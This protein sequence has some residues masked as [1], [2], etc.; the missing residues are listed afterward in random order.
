[1]MS[2]AAL[3]IS[4]NNTYALQRERNNEQLRLRMAVMRSKE[5]LDKE[6]EFRRHQMEEVDAIF[7]SIALQLKPHKKED[8][9]LSHLYVR[10]STDLDIFQK[11]LITECSWVGVGNQ[12]PLQTAQKLQETIPAIFNTGT[13]LDDK[14]NAVMAFRDHARNA[15]HSEAFKIGLAA[16]VGALAFAA[17]IFGMIFGVIGAK[18]FFAK[19]FFSTF[20]MIQ[21]ILMSGVGACMG[22]RI[23]TLFCEGQNDTRGQDVS[24]DLKLL[25]KQR[26][27]LFT[28]KNER[29]CENTE[30]LLTQMSKKTA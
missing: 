15:K 30:T 22:A 7:A 17:L 16:L 13:T 11:V 8:T 10:L 28:A 14:Q 18:L 20:T 24:A 4:L 12:T 23:G 1:M 27:G 2:T 5:E 26:H 29:D 25:V 21:G 19:P 9:A 6:F 3:S